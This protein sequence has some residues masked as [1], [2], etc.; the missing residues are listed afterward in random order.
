MFYIYSTCVFLSTMVYVHK[1]INSEHFI[2]H[3][4]LEQATTI[5]CNSVLLKSEV[6]EQS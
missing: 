2:S 3:M 5:P 4:K 6:L 1:K